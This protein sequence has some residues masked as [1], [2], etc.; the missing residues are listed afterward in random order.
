[1]F[2]SYFLYSYIFLY[3]IF[4]IL[5]LILYIIYFLYFLILSFCSLKYKQTSIIFHLTLI[6]SINSLFPFLSTKELSTEFPK[7]RNSHYPP[8]SWHNIISVKLAVKSKSTRKTRPP[9]AKIIDTFLYA[10]ITIRWQ[11]RGT[12]LRIS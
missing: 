6:N 8:L 7:I 10:R 1:M 12:L 11:V 3:Y 5:Y 9:N 2:H 4:Y